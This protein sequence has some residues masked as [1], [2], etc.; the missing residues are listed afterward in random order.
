MGFDFKFSLENKNVT[1]DQWKY[2][3]MRFDVFFDFKGYT[4]V[5]YLAW[6]NGRGRWNGEKYVTSNF[7]FGI[8]RPYNLTFVLMNSGFRVSNG[9]SYVL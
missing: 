4:N 8:Q 9:I 5:V 3:A 2:V 7:P 1:D 6:E